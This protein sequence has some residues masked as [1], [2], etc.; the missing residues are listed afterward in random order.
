MA[1]SRFPFE[2]QITKMPSEHQYVI[3]NLWNAIADVQGA[4]P[5]LKSQITSN[6]SSI[7][8]VN[9]TINSTSSTESVTQVVNSSSTIGGVNNQTGNVTY[10]T[11]QADNG[12]FIIFDDAYPVAVSLTGVPVIQLPWYCIIINYGVGLVTVTPLAGTITYPSNIGAASMGVPQGNAAIIAYD[13]VNYWAILIQVSSVS[14]QNTP[15]ILHEWFNAY[16]SVTGLF[17]Q[18]QPAFTDISGIASVAQGGTGTSTPSLVAGSNVTITGSWPNQTVAATGGGSGTITGVTAGTGLSGGGSSGAVT[19]AIANT[20]V[21]AGSYTN[22]NVTVNAQGQVTAAANG[23][24]SGGYPSV[25]DSY[26]NT[27]TT[28]TSPSIYSRTFPVV[29]AGLYRV[30]CYGSMRS[31]TGVGTAQ[32][33]AQATFTDSTA[34]NTITF[35]FSPSETTPFSGANWELYGQCVFFSSGSVAPFIQISAIVTGAAVATFIVQGVVLERLA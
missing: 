32:I 15:A 24:V 6:T 12:Y 7:K 29:P 26:T 11:A 19:L 4:V 13:G 23:S 27:S 22:A 2:A 1:I 25:S 34:A 16:N 30:S 33:Q 21:T 9:E 5:I 28:I 20:A 17:S 8:T 14:S 18:T 31:A 35:A 10:S 3:R